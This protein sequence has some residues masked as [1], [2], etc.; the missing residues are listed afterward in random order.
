MRRHTMTQDQN[1]ARQEVNKVLDQQA[2]K[3]IKRNEICRSLFSYG[4][5]E[6]QVGAVMGINAK[7]AHASKLS[8][9]DGHREK[10]EIKSFLVLDVIR[11][12]GFLKNVKMMVGQPIHPKQG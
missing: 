8:I 9:R 1:K 12:Q 6:H 11:L 7:S 10:K 2:A 4:F 5:S 3:G